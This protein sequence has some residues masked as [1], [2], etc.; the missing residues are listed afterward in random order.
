MDQSIFGALAERYSAKVMARKE[1]I[2]E[3]AAALHASKRAIFAV[4]RGDLEE[5]DELLRAAQEGII[6]IEEKAEILPELHYEG[7]VH[8]AEE[9]Y[10]EALLYSAYARTG[11]VVIPQDV[12][13]DAETILGA[14]SDLTGELQRRQVLR[15]VAGDA[16]TV[17]KITEDI[18][19]IVAQLLA[20]DLEGS[21][22]TKFD[23][24]KNSL[25]RAEDVLYDL[26]M[27]RRSG[28]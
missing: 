4:H 18:R 2:A 12:Y 17:Q 26:A 19:E 8:A 20:M 28:E 5:A 22:R 1:V 3:A 13:L 14:L 25:R 27:R 16:Q 24:A 21:L 23:Q 10:V 7:S 9:E 11:E 15:A 6:A